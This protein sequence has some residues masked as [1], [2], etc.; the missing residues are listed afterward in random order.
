MSF[1]FQNRVL[2][3]CKISVGWGHIVEALVDFLVVITVLG[4]RQIGSVAVTNGQWLVYHLFFSAE[5][6]LILWWGVVKSV[7]FFVSG[8]LLFV[9]H[10][11]DDWDPI[12]ITSWSVAAINLSFSDSWSWFKMCTITFN[13]S[14]IF[15]SKLLFLA[16]PSSSFI[17]LLLLNF[18][19][20]QRSLWTI[21]GFSFWD[22]VE[23]KLDG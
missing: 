13:E 12:T 16:I 10:R 5:E 4:D 21:D 17:I 23:I 22:K 14:L 3:T 8:R 1:C 6:I 20:R 2:H 18:F 9:Q 11:L 15:R 19:L 7:L